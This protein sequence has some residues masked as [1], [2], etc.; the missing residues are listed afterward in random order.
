MRAAFDTPNN[1]CESFYGA[2]RSKVD[3]NVIKVGTMYRYQIKWFSDVL[4]QTLA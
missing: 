2:Q 4:G 1:L 3:C